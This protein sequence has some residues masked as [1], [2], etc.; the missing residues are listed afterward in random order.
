MFPKLTED[1]LIRTMNTYADAGENKAL[2]ADQLG[3]TR[4]T[5]AA[6]LDRARKDGIVG[7]TTLYKNV[8]RDVPL[9]W[10]RR[11]FQQDKGLSLEQVTD[12]IKDEF[13]AYKG[14]G[15][16]TPAPAIIN[17][18][19]ITFY[20]IP[21]LHLGMYA[22]SKETGEPYD[23][24]I[25][26]RVATASI[27]DLVSRTPQ[28][29]HAV[30]LN[31]GD[32][33]HSDNNE[34][35][36]L[37]SRNVLDSDTRYARV[38]RVG[39][40]LMLSA[41]ELIAQKHTYVEVVNI[42]G[43]HDPY[44]TLALTNSLWVRY[45]N[46]P[47]I[48]VNSSPAPFYFRQFGKVLVGAAHGDYAKPYQMPGIMAAKVPLLWG[49]SLW[50]YIYMGHLHKKMKGNNSPTSDETGGAIW[51]VFQTVAPRDAWGN[52][53]GYTAGRSMQAITHHKDTGEWDRKTS[54]IVQLKP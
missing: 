53:M 36:T 14:V 11:R 22:W 17:A 25:A 46:H 19:L 34:N 5:L 10:V 16:V 37:K 29:E 6:R 3:I 52:A 26:K 54:G 18:D 43:N 48:T 1:E 12:I 9:Q 51:E 50:R 21:D 41:A 45:A 33:F 35:R 8:E 23:V 42:P 38:L 27:E 13:N 39:T 2:A 15:T 47:R 7:T 49:Q 24:D 20:L 31:L 28:S 30:L 32:F 4:S 40:N 44:G